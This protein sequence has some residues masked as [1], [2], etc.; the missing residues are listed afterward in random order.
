MLIGE[1]IM[2]ADQLVP[3]LTVPAL[4]GGISFSWA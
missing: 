4:T 1:M 2:Q 3:V